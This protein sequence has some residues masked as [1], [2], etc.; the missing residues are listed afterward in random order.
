[1]GLFA[2]SL[3]AYLEYLPAYATGTQPGAG[4][5]ERNFLPFVSW[6]AARGEVLTF[7]AH[8][9]MEAVGINTPDDLR[10]VEAFLAR[11]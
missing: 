9:R 7:P 3:A 4:T 2:L 1:M 5:G 11:H 6:M 10:A 8:D